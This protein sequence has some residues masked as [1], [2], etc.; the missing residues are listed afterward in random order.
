LLLVRSVE[1]GR[2]R[3]GFRALVR[4]DTNHEVRAAIQEG[5]EPIPMDAENYLYDIVRQGGQLVHGWTR[6]GLMVASPGSNRRLIPASELEDAEVFGFL[7][8]GWEVLI[9]DT[10]VREG[11]SDP[12]GFDES[13][14]RS[15]HQSWM[16]GKVDLLTRWARDRGRARRE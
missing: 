15:V 11:T 9:Y 14:P 13:I 6:D 16:R 1:A 3:Y 5:A 7:D 4:I 2:I 12:Y 8:Q 10:A